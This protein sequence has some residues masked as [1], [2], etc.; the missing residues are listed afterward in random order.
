MAVS[1]RGP[2]RRLAA[3]GSVVANAFRQPE[4]GRGHPRERLAR[5]WGRVTHVVLLLLPP[6]NPCRS[7]SRPEAPLHAAALPAPHMPQAMGPCA[8]ADAC[9]TRTES[10][11]RPRAAAPWP[12]LMRPARSQPEPPR[13][14]LVPAAVAWAP[15]TSPVPALPAI[16]IHQDEGAGGNVT[17][18]ARDGRR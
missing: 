4:A 14:R 5:G 10:H 7:G 6:V 11:S 15:R 3:R 2:A 13:K 8:S 16:L 18:P 17:G 9:V 1:A 12:L